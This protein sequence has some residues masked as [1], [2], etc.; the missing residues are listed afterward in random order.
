MVEIFQVIHV[1]YIPMINA[2]ILS[3]LVIQRRV[4]HNLQPIPAL[5]K[6]KRRGPGFQS[7]N[8]PIVSK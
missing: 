1:D 3:F 6:K 5:D 4:V 7:K 8:H 2:N